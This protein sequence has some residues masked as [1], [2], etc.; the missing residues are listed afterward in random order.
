ML[1][2]VH[3]SVKKTFILK[4]LSEFIVTDTMTINNLDF[5][6][7]IQSTLLLHLL[8]HFLLLLCTSEIRN[9][10]NRFI[11]LQ[12]KK[13]ISILT[14]PAIIWNTVGCRPRSWYHFTVKY[15]KFFNL[16]STFSTIHLWVYKMIPSF[17]RFT[18]WIFY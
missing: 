6:F 14:I 5:Y 18:W 8:N 1:K 16:S 7:V 3:Y 4:T 13:H 2:L 10:G 9:E 12:K 17:L 15:W 11:S